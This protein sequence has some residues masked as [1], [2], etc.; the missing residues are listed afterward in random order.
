MNE[1]KRE[2]IRLCE[3][4]C[5]TPV[6]KKTEWPYTF[7]R[8]IH[9]HAARVQSEETRRKIAEAGKGRAWSEKSRK[10][11][12]QAKMGNII[13]EEAR[14]KISL[15][16]RMNHLK[17]EYH[18]ELK[19]VSE[20]NIHKIVRVGGKGLY[21]KFLDWRQAVLS[22]DHDRCVFCGVTNKR[23]CAHHIEPIQFF[24]KNNNIKTV[25]DVVECEDLWDI[26]IGITLCGGCHSKLHFLAKKMVKKPE[27][28]L[29][30][31]S[32]LPSGYHY[33]LEPIL[34]SLRE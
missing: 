27:L 29:S 13:S 30:E 31:Y 28:D 14:K 7:N 34:D 16:N 32:W 23:L 1:E 22:F 12:S 4:G 11:L 6:R 8:F 26:N 5:G 24:I 10:K 3:C 18:D 20:G 33:L 17:K 21:R 15:A 9:G 2:E 25:K 19:L